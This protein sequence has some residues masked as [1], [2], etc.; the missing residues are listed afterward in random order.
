MSSSLSAT[1]PSAHLWLS[2]LRHLDADD[3]VEVVGELK[4]HR[5]V[6][7]H[8]AGTNSSRATKAAPRV[9]LETARTI[10]CMAE[11]PEPQPEASQ[12]KRGAGS[13]GATGATPTNVNPQALAAA[14]TASAESTG[15]SIGC[16]YAARSE[17]VVQTEDGAE[18]PRVG[19]FPIG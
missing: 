11:S 4:P 12:R 9:R 2:G 5:R 16:K 1:L 3:A 15:G 8:P 17:R 10:L 19:T 13:R 6:R 14:T 7:G 18:A